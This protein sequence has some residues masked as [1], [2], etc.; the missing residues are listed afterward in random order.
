MADTA[1]EEYPRKRIKL[2]ENTAEDGTE[3]DDQL[4][5]EIRAGIT[6]FVCPKTAGFSG[7]LKQRYVY[8]LQRSFRA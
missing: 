6:H 3:D 1:A 4:K 8:P 5:R 7:I 2:G